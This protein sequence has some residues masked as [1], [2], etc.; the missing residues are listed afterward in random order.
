MRVVGCA[1]VRQLQ[2]GYMHVL[3]MLPEHCI[4]FMVC[5]AGPHL[6]MWVLNAD[7]STPLLLHCITN[8]QADPS[9]SWVAHQ[10]FNDTYATAQTLQGY[11]QQRQ[12]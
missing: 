3:V 9:C 6:H 11:W 1:G 8:Q 4:W 5:L 10:C 7:T 2:N 12:Q